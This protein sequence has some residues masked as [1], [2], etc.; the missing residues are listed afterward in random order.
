MG[1]AHVRPIFR[2]TIQTCVS[3]L[4][5]EEDYA[6][7]VFSCVRCVGEAGWRGEGVRRMSVARLGLSASPP[8]SLVESQ[9]LSPQRC[10]RTD[11]V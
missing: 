5:H 3:A 7:Q 9:L 6:V 1:Y 11:T 2:N 8:P 10:Y 4:S